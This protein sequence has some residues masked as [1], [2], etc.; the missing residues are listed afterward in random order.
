[1]INGENISVPE[2]MYLMMLD[3]VWMKIRLVSYG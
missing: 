2:I 1:M 3:I